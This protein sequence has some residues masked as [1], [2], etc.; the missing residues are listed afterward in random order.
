METRKRAQSALVSS[1]QRDLTAKQQAT[2]SSPVEVSQV[3]F[4]DTEIVG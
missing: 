1:I 4:F 3:P 2:S